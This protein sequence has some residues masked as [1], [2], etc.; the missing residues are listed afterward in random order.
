M[1][2]ELNRSI[3]ALTGLLLVA[4][5]AQAQEVVLSAE[6]SNSFRPAVSLGG[7]PGV[8]VGA[9]A[10][11]AA[12]SMRISLGPR[13]FFMPGIAY[14]GQL[15]DYTGSSPPPDSASSLHTLEVPLRLFHIL[16]EHWALAGAFAP[17]L[18]GNFAGLDRHFRFSGAALA[19][20]AFRRDFIVGFGAGVD[21][22]A[23]RWLPLPV[24]TLDW[25]IVDGLYLKMLG[26]IAK[27][28]YRF[29]D[30]V[31]AGAFTQFDA[32][33]WAVVG[34]SETHTIDSF[35]VDVGGLLDVRIGGTTWLN[36]LAGWSPFRRYEIDGGPRAGRYDAQPG[37]LLRAGVEVRFPGS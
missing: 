3:L 10:V 29:G 17:G 11:Q 31:E 6:A 34:A 9:N 4:R 8:D 15:L 33:R 1:R 36:V 12:V 28:Y 30:R 32:S 23:G 25:Q 13:T 20:Y 22:G 35:A 26:P 18:S 14:R 7:A 24:L 37:V 21:Y 19:T 27:L 2:T 16:D 5:Q